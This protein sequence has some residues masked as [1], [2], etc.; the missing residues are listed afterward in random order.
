MP[1]LRQV[2]RAEATDKTVLRMY[3]ALFGAR[4]LFVTANEQD[5]QRF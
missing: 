4:E 5:F 2:A 1:R 3:D